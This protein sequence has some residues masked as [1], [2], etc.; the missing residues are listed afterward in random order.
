MAKKGLKGLTNGSVPFQMDSALRQAGKMLST[1]GPKV[2]GSA[3]GGVTSGGGQP[4][5]TA[6]KILKPVQDLSKGLGGKDIR[7]MP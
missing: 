7:L 2:V 3:A 1:R 5:V 6:G 4:D